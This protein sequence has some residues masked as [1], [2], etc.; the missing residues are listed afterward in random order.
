MISS[1]SRCHPDFFWRALRRRLFAA[2]V[3]FIALVSSANSTLDR[4]EATALSRYGD[5]VAERVRQWRS[6]L[7]TANEQSERDQLR[8]INQFFNRNIQFSD[9]PVVWRSKDY[10]ATPLETF[11]KGAGDCEDFVIAKYLSL[12]L[13]GIP[14]SKLRLIYV[15][16]RIGGPNSS[17]TQAH[18]VLG[19]YET[20]TAEPLVLDN[21]LGDIQPASRRTDLSPIFSFNSSGLWVQGASRPSASSTER[22][23]RWRDLVARLT[24]EGFEP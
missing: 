13:L 24:E 6:A 20:P 15:R 16:A 10:W 9:D 19:Y 22:L 11:S 14:D 2:G 7:N 17:L 4:V 5:T 21:L 1:S 3:F 18:M 23:S 8:D 12:R